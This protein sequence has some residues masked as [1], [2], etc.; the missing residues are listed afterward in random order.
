MVGFSFSDV[1]T[2]HPIETRD[3]EASLGTPTDASDQF[4][5]KDLTLRITRPVS[6]VLSWTLTAD[7]ER[8]FEAF[9]KK[10]YAKILGDPDIQRA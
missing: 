2:K 10:C 9:E 8:R 7:L 1:K 3:A 5:Y 6:R 4:S